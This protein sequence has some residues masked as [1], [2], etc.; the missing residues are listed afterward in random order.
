MLREWITQITDLTL[1]FPNIILICLKSKPCSDMTVYFF[2]A[3]SVSLLV[4][5]TSQKQSA[6]DRKS[7]LSKLITITKTELKSRGGITNKSDD[8]RYLSWPIKCR[9]RGTN[10]I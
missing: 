8:F 4:I 6:P 3:V 2:R 7:L 9:S 10:E 5:K 1:R